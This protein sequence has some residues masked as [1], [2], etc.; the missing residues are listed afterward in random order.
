[1]KITQSPTRRKTHFGDLRPG[2]GFEC[3]GSVYVKTA[4]EM[5]VDVN[6][7]IKWVKVN[8]F[9][10]RTLRVEQ[11]DNNTGVVKVD[12]ELIVS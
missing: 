2:D 11:Y 4:E 3:S 1:M 12:L 7:G 9:N 10:M 8:C 5:C 6:V